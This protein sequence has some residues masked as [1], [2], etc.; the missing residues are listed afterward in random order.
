MECGFSHKLRW[1]PCK[2]A[3]LGKTGF[4]FFLVAGSRVK[5]LDQG[6]V[7]RSWSETTAKGVIVTQEV[8]GKLRGV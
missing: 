1:N 3:K 8:R 7:P 5:S 2:L 4:S 6:P